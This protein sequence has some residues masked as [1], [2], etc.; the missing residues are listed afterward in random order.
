MHTVQGLL[1]AFRRH[2]RRSFHRWSLNGRT[3]KAQRE[4]FQGGYTV[5]FS[6]RLEG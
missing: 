5:R 3:V 1:R 4:A 2:A 6:W